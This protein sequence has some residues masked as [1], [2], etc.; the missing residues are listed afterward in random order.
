[1]IWQ[2]PESGKKVGRNSAFYGK[3]VSVLPIITHSLCF[4]AEKHSANDDS[5]IAFLA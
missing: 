3:A 1:L 2:E 4:T 5:A